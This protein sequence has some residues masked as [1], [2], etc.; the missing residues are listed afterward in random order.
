[1]TTPS[2]SYSALARISRR[3]GTSARAFAPGGD[4]SLLGQAH[5]P[6]EQPLGIL[7][8]A[9]LARIVDAQRPAAEDDQLLGRYLGI[10]L[11]LELLPKILVGPA[12]IEIGLRRR[13]S[14]RQHKRQAA[15][16]KFA[17]RP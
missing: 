14:S 3:C 15:G 5:Q 10:G 1:M 11:A 4:T 12:A 8:I 6:L 9:G 7:H 2:P 13:G 16:R 17:K